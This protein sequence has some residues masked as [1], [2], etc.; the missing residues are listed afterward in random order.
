MSYMNKATAPSHWTSHA[1]A[2]GLRPVGYCRNKMLDA[3]SVNHVHAC[4]ILPCLH[5]ELHDALT[6]DACSAG[7]ES[8]V[9]NRHNRREASRPQHLAT[10]PHVMKTLNSREIITDALQ[11]NPLCLPKLPRSCCRWFTPRALCGHTS[12]WAQSSG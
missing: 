2:F 1:H 3:P 8:A 4:R 12:Q 6:V 10:D 7:S 5:R 11:A 9:E